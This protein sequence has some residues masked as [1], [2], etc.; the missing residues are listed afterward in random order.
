MPPQPLDQVGAA[1]EDAGLRA[2]EEL[3]AREAHEVG[4]GGE[5]R[6]G[7]R[8]VA[9]RRERARAEIVDERQPGARRDR[10][11]LGE[12]GL[13]GEADDAE[14][15]L[16]D[17]QDH[18]RLGPERTLVVGDTGAVRGADLDEPR[19]RA[20]E[21]VGDPEAAADLDQLAA[22][23]EHLAALASAARASSTA[24]A[25]L[26]TTSAA[27][28]PVIRCSS[29]GEMVLARAARPGVEVELEVGVAAADLDDASSAACASGARPRFVWITTPVALITRRSDGG[30]RRPAPRARLDG[31]ARIAA[32]ADLFAGALERGARGRQC[33]R[34][35]GAGEA[36]RPAR[37]RR[38]EASQRR[39]M[40]E[41]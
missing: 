9:D 3:V 38:T 32:G 35:R 15:G 5:A 12:R 31:I 6:R 21:H 40:A 7:G 27:S 30:W 17:A 18:G 2:A 39:A 11:Q 19:A 14:V 13:L 22:R 4:A 16:V 20:G 25:L 41:V 29:A 23:D 36:G 24:A 8:L 37:G 28:A 26:L 10:G 1:G 34:P 33:Q